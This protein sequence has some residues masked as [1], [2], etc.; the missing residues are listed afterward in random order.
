VYFHDFFLVSIIIMTYTLKVTLISTVIT[1]CKQ[2]AYLQHRTLFTNI[3]TG[4][5]PESCIC[6]IAV[7]IHCSNGPL[8]L[9]SLM[10]NYLISMLVARSLIH[11]SLGELHEL[12]AYMF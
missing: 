6:F 1:V 4:T 8:N 10:L 2:K 7:G 5:H 3:P 12:V 9:Q 11:L